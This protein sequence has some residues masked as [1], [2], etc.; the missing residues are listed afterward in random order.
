ML[1]MRH[2]GWAG[3][4]G[5]CSDLCMCIRITLSSDLSAAVEHCE[6]EDW[7]QVLQVSPEISPA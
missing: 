5:Q 6:L 1:R 4:K 2:T 7:V 3:C